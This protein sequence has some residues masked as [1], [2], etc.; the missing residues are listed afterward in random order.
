MQSP[1]TPASARGGGFEA[2]SKQRFVPTSRSL[3]F[4]SSSTPNTPNTGR[5]KARGQPRHSA[6]NS[7]DA[8]DDRKQRLGVNFRPILPPPQLKGSL[9]SKGSLRV[10]P[11]MDLRTEARSAPTTPP[12]GFRPSRSARLVKKKLSRHH[13]MPRLSLSTTNS[14]VTSPL[15][16]RMSTSV[17]GRGYNSPIPPKLSLT[18][19]RGD[20]RTLLD[21]DPNPDIPK[22][23][24]S[25]SLPG[26]LFSPTTPGTEWS[27]WREPSFERVV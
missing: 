21:G 10:V 11:S 13:R 4:L 16:P 8:D 12:V 3:K 14:R 25:P 2:L 18:N 23:T 17:R 22:L 1:N 7:P 26:G 24:L 27:Q 19:C 6:P 15:P 9:V 20:S 5:T